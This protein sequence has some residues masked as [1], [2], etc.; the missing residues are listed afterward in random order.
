MTQELEIGQEYEINLYAG[1]DFRTVAFTA[2][3]MGDGQWNTFGDDWTFPIHPAHDPRP[4]LASDN[5]LLPEKN[6]DVMSPPMSSEWGTSELVDENVEFGV[7]LFEPTHRHVGRSGL[8]N[9]G[10]YEVIAEGYLQVSDAQWDEASVTIYRGAD[11][12]WWVRPTEEFNDGR[13]EAV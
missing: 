8:G 7:K 2:R 12:K 10:L 13:F 5:V 9:Q 11:G 1:D 6:F 4:A 3:Y